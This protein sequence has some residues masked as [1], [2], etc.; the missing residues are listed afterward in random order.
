[1]KC[2][3]NYLPTPK[4]LN[5]RALH[6]NVSLRWLKT[7]LWAVSGKLR[8]GACFKLEKQTWRQK[9]SGTQMTISRKLLIKIL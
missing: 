9:S 7:V 5:F 2:S 4:V 3:E 6:D 8:D 1:M